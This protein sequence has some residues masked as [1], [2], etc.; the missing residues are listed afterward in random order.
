MKKLIFVTAILFTHTV[1]FAQFLPGWVRPVA[2][3][4]MT[5]H[6]A[7]GIFSDY[8]EVQVIMK[9]VD[10]QDA[11]RFELIFNGK[12]V[13][14]VSE[15]KAVREEC[16]S[17]VYQARAVDA[18]DVQLTLVDHSR[19]LCADKPSDSWQATLVHSLAGAITSSAALDGSVNAIYTITN[20]DL[21]DEGETQLVDTL[22]GDTIK[23]L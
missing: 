21:A 13:E 18:A 16:G 8:R 3:S 10:G 17:H 20:V 2:E 22:I 15:G 6:Q 9:T 11:V 14:F 4:T 7:T 12:S 23:D 1:A 5:V 19:R